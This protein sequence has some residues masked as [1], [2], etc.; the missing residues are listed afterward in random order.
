MG[1]RPASRPHAEVLA[2]FQARSRPSKPGASRAFASY[3][4]AA[5]SGECPG[6][7]CSGAAL[8]ADSATHSQQAFGYKRAGWC[9]Q[10]PAINTAHAEVPAQVYSLPG[11]KADRAGHGGK[12]MAVQRLVAS[13]VMRK[14]EEFRPG[15]APSD[16]RTL[17]GKA[18]HPLTIERF[19]ASGKTHPD[20]MLRSRPVNARRGRVLRIAHR[21]EA[22]AFLAAVVSGGVEFHAH[23]EQ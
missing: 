8:C 6:T 11:S 5:A 10:L 12:A 7:L 20:K 15:R 21:P 1:L 14:V 2:R 19:A 9:R 18:L 4:R 16:G 3:V 22:T 17:A 13:G 23:A